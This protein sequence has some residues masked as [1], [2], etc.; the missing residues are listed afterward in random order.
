M[1][2]GMN[3]TGCFVI[4]NYGPDERTDSQPVYLMSPV[5]GHAHTFSANICKADMFATEGLA[6]SQLATENELL[7]EDK[8]P[9]AGHLFVAEVFTRPMP[10]EG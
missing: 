1:A 8:H 4:C 5:F 10:K 9:L 2:K 7:K 3:N 6:K